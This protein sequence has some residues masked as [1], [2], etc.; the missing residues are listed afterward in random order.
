MSVIQNETRFHSGDFLPHSSSGTG[1]TASPFWRF[2]SPNFTEPSILISEENEDDGSEGFNVPAWVYVVMTSLYVCIFVLGIAG[3]LLVIL[4]I[5]KDRRMRTTANFYLIS[6]SVAD[7]MIIAFC[8]PV[9]VY[10]LH[11]VSHFK[12]L[13]STHSLR[14]FYVSGRSMVFGS[15][16]M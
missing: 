3:N 7:L 4:V 14:F 15:R 8:L 2:N 16:L 13:L 9:A 12:T 5:A 1:V 11:S 10:E 6:L